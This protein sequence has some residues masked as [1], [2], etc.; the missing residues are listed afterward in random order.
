VTRR[1]LSVVA[2][3][4]ACAAPAADSAGAAT[5]LSYS[6]T[7]TLACLR[8]KGAVVGRVVPVNNRMRALRDLAQKTS[9]QARVGK[10]TIGLV[11]ARSHSEAVLLVELLTVPRDP[12]LLERHD[13]VVVLSPKT[14]RAARS[15][16]IGCL[17]R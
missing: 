8:K 6:R 11:F 16:V 13:N 4:L 10:A 2:V 17:K 12:Y 5:Q 1:R 14:A 3:A 9:V 15:S 7:P